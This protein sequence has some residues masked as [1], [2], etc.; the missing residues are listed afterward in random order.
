[1]GATSSACISLPHPPARLAGSGRRR[2]RELRPPELRSGPALH[3]GSILRRPNR[4]RLLLCL[5]PVNDRASAAITSNRHAF[6]WTQVRR[7]GA[8]SVPPVSSASGPDP[9]SVRSRGSVRLRSRL[10]PPEEEVRDGHDPGGADDRHH[11]GPRPLRASDLACWPPL[12][13]DQ[14][15]KLEDAFGNCRD[16]EQP[17]GALAEV[18]P[19]PPGGHAIP[20]THG[21]IPMVAPYLG[22]A[23][24]STRRSCP[25]CRVHPAGIEPATHPCHR[26]AGVHEASQNLPSLYKGPAGRRCHGCGRGAAR[27]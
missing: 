16:G 5:L 7:R 10:S 8:R 20:H 14:R 19:L 6:G 3:C 11:R 26:C 12:Q 13:V 23:S 4:P 2:E 21:M 18:T 1:M 27:G 17:A 22:L 9:A 24:L 25:S 15:R